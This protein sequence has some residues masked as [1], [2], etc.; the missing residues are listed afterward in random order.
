[1]LDTLLRPVKD[2]ALM[3]LAEGI[4]RSLSPMAITVIGFGFGLAAV[5]AAV[6]GSNVLTLILWVLNR[7][8]DGLD[9]L[10]A[11]HYGKQSDLGGYTDILLDMAIYALLPIGLVLGSPQTE[12]H[13]L[14]LA[15]LLASFY[16]NAGS[17]MYLAALLEA[18]EQGARARGE[19][20]S[21]S[22]PRGLVEG[23]E[24]II[25]FTLFIVL[26]DLLVLL[27]A[28]MGLLV[29]VTVIQRW[30]WSARHLR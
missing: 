30:L 23:A 19:S 17:W 22:M 16:L 13:F 18:R 2:R 25:F 24:T 11:R 28:L 12:A 3:P 26:S 1:M 5:G 21:I 8:F 14:A 7:I 6:I 20:T 29:L 9:G 10:A 15:L 27:F 4:G